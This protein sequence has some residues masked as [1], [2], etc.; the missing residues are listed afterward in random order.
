MALLLSDSPHELY[1]QPRLS[2]NR[3]SVMRMFPKGVIFLSLHSSIPY[4]SQSQ[5][6]TLHSFPTNMRVLHVGAEMM[7]GLAACPVRYV[8]ILIANH[9][10]PPPE[11]AWSL[12]VLRIYPHRTKPKESPVYESFQASE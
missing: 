10:L 6:S 11:A 9:L 2:P 1:M 3:H 8:H 5:D 7:P 4:L 12:V